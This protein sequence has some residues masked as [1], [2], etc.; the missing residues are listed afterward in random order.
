[1][2]N[3]ELIQALRSAAATT[4]LD[5]YVELMQ[6]AADALSAI[7]PIAAPVTDDEIDAA[8]DA[9][10]LIRESTTVGEVRRTLEGF[11]AGRAAGPAPT[12][13]PPEWPKT[14]F[15][16]VKPGLEVG[17]DMMGGVDIRL[18]GD[19]VYVHINYDYRYTHNSARKALADNIVRLLTE[20]WP[21]AHPATEDHTSMTQPQIDAMMN[22]MGIYDGDYETAIVRA[23]EKHHEIK[24]ATQ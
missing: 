24:G 16:E 12:V 22:N 3:T 14:I 1:M 7:R 23:V 19:F 10:G 18:G 4:G 8:F 2:D 17:Y 13:A 9:L 15:K 21:A 20:G 5:A 6:K 11:A